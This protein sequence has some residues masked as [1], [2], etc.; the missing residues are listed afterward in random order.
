LVNPI[1]FI[2]EIPKKLLTDNEK[3]NDGFHIRD[4]RIWERVKWLLNLEKLKAR[5]VIE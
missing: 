2:E 1:P 4:E 5:G 3:C